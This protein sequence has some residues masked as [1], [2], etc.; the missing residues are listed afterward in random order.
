MRRTASP[1]RGK[2][3]SPPLDVASLRPSQQF[4]QRCPG[5]DI[6][7]RA[8]Q[9]ALFFHAE[10]S[11]TGGFTLVTSPSGSIVSTPLGTLRRMSSVSAAARSAGPPPGTSASRSRVPWP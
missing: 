11:Q 2:T 5:E 6:G 8:P 3:A 7:G 9:N 10:D 4:A 1:G